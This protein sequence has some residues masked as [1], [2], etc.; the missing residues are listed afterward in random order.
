MHGARLRDG[1]EVAVKVQ[2]PDI[3]EIVRVDIKNLRRACRIYERLDP[4]PLELLPLLEELVGH[5][6]L[7]LD[8]LREAE[9]AERVRA[10]LR[11]DDRVRRARDP[12][13]V[14]DARACW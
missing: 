10:T 13:R 8:F 4:Q 2:Y 14:V 9:S 3:E 11:R 7:E 1:R 12:P 6:A 5:T